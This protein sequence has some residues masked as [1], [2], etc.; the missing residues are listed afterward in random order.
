MDLIEIRLLAVGGLLVV[1]VVTTGLV[2]AIGAA[3]DWVGRIVRA[4]RAQAPG[5]PVVGHARNLGTERVRC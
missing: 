4:R 3:A 1:G 5:S 2:M